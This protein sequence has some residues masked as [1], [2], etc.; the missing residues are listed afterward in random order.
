[1]PRGIPKPKSVQAERVTPDKPDSD[2][3]PRTNRQAEESPAGRPGARPPAKRRTRG[4]KPPAATSPPESAPAKA[5]DTSSEALAA[6]EAALVDRYPARR[7]KPGSLRPAGADPAFG[8]KRTVV[9]HCEDCGAERMVAT[10]D[11]FH[12]G[13]CTACR[14]ASRKGGGRERA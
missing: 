9:I 5:T 13:R 2:G 11:L 3:D 8:T 14:R 10:S 7:I 4:A 12:V 6:A 1:M